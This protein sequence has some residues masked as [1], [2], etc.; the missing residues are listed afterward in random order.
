VALGGGVHSQV[1]AGLSPAAISAYASAA[2]ARDEAPLVGLSTMTF[3]ELAHETH[4]GE[5]LTQQ[6][7]V[8][9]TISWPREHGT[10]SAGSRMAGTVEAPF[11]CT[12]AAGCQ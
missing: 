1:R 3:H 12:I 5:A 4:F 8:T 11:D 6:Y 2:S 7:P 9:P 10:S